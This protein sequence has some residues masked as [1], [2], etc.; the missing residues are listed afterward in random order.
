MARAIQPVKAKGE[1]NVGARVREARTLLGVS[2]VDLAKSLEQGERT[3]QA[4]ERNERRPRMKSLVRLGE[5]VDRP[6][7][8]FYGDDSEP[9]D[10][11]A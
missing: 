2:Q 4:W 8:W 7:A 6:V 3:V 5:M 1:P 10:V 9:E 11:A